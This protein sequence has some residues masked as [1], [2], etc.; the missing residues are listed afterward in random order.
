L[1]DFDG[2][3][4][5]DLI[6]GSDDCCNGNHEFFVWRRGADGR[7][8][9][10][11]AISTRYAHGKY[12]LLMS[13]GIKVYVTDW[14]RDGHPDLIMR[15]HGVAGLLIAPG[16]LADRSEIELA[17]RIEGSDSLGRAKSY[18]QTK[19]NVADWD[20]DG[21][22]DVLVG[23][24]MEGPQGKG[25]YVLRGVQD[26]EEFHFA[27]PELLIAAPDGASV[28][29]LDVADWDGDGVL[30]LIVGLTWRE[31]IGQTGGAYKSRSQV[32]VYRRIP[33]P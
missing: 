16:P 25:I 26:A 13:P 23:T 18:T 27:A 10:R 22:P 21:L 33:P 5:L 30:D 20:G 32:W 17:A 29:G 14:N 11:E 2:N 7:F 8:G 4:R 12:P 9:T 3:G 1:V 24:S 15:G 31:R 28:T 19:P 6:S